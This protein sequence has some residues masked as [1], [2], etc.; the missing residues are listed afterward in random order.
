MDDRQIFTRKN[1]LEL[2]WD[3]DDEGP[4]EIMFQG[5]DKE[6]GLDEVDDENDEPE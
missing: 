1:V 6:F 3:E 2:I 5:S 4:P